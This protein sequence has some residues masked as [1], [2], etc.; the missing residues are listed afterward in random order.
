MIELQQNDIHFWYTQPHHCYD[1]VLLDSLKRLLTNEEIQ[2]QQRY[3]FDKDKHDALI[4]RAFIRDLLSR[5]VD[6][7]STDWRFSKGEKGKPEIINPEIPIR[8]NI[9]HTKNLIICAI[10]LEKDIGC[11][12]ENVNRRND[13]LA[14][15]DRFFSKSE[16]DSMFL[17]PKS[18]QR[19]R[20]F[21]LWTLKESYIKAWGQG[22]S[23]PLNEFSFH[24]GKNQNHLINTDIHL[25]FDNKRN[26]NPKHWACWLFYPNKEHRVAVSIRNDS[27]QEGHINV[28]DFNLKY[29]KSVPLVSYEEIQGGFII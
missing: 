24:I 15:S 27:L 11:D 9:S 29:F 13:I 22:L 26:D 10:T 1:P 5:Y 3:L 25:S 7:P 19:D 14:I 20:F 12:V 23:I 2:R 16:V 18:E 21:D 28:T 8:F 6:K 4:T 17:L